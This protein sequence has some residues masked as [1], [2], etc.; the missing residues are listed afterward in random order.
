[1]RV[2]KARKRPIEIAVAQIEREA[3][4]EAVA[5]WVRSGGGSA[6]VGGPELL[7]RTKE[8]ELLAPV[9]SYIAC[10]AH[11]EFYP[12][13]PEIFADTYDVVDCGHCRRPGCELCSSKESAA[14]QVQERI[15][16]SEAWWNR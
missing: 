5:A 8:G 16:T 15:D 13:A 10:G 1:M 4:L 6:F 14:R 9:G 7:I 12:I 3:D 2:Q 11:G